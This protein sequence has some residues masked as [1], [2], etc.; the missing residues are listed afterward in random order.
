MAVASRFMFGLCLVAVVACAAP[1]KSAEAL[2]KVPDA[3]NS[4]LGTAIANQ[5]VYAANKKPV[6]E[7]AAV[8]P[9]A[10]RGS[11]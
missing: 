11:E 9:A 1:V 5:Q 3:K 8:E 2:A 10:Y 6:V 4:R 7:V